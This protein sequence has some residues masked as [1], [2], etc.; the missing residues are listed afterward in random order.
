[1]SKYLYIIRHATAEETSSSDFNR[2]LSDDGQEEALGTAQAIYDQ[3]LPQKLISSDA[4]RTKQTS[5]KIGD[6]L[7]IPGNMISYDRALYNCDAATLLSIVQNQDDSTGVIAL[8]GHNPSVT[9]LV[10]HLSG[11]YIPLKP[12]MVVQLSFEAKRWFDVTENKGKM[13]WRHQP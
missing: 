1:M 6:I 13:L 7:N 9:E 8:V 4:L 10:S 2:A 5:E 11:I 12:S 3:A